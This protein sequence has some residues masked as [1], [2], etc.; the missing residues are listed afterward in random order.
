MY[1]HE[2]GSTIES[3]VTLS[4]L[5]IKCPDNDP[6][7]GTETIL[8]GSKKVRDVGPDTESWHWDFMPLAK[9]NSLKAYCVDRSAWVY[10]KTLMSD[11]TY[12]IFHCLMV[13]P[14][15]ERNSN[16]RILDLTIN[17][18]FLQEIVEEEV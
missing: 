1:L 3:M 9:R 14:N 15:R 8:L 10:I 4:S 17:F 12:K 2:I 7:E 11:D 13:W 18:M 16:A 6:S 5:G